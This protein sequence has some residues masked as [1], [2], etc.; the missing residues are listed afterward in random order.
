MIAVRLLTGLSLDTPKA[1]PEFWSSS[2]N[3]EV[4]QSS[5]DLSPASGHCRDGT[6]L[7]RALCKILCGTARSVSD[8]RPA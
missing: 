1:S 5:C 3:E 2:P 7:F 6:E 4:T 8:S